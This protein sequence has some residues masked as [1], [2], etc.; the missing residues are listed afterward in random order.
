MG[1]IKAISWLPN[2]DVKQKQ[3]PLPYHSWKCRWNIE[4]EVTGIIKR[5]RR[6]DLQVEEEGNTIWKSQRTRKE[7]FF[8]FQNF[9]F[10]SCIL[11]AAFNKNPENKWEICRLLPLGH[12]AWRRKMANDLVSAWMRVNSN[13]DFTQGICLISL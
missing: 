7:H 11:L 1:R 10:Y 5:A 3:Q 9:L 6:Q 2:P 8:L 13:T 4:V 12:R